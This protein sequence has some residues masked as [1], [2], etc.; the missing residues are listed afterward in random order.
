MW[1]QRK[2][3]NTKR[4]SRIQFYHGPGSF[5]PKEGIVKKKEQEKKR[6]PKSSE[7]GFVI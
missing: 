6:I 5:N 2:A 1:S 3:M 7:S 4:R